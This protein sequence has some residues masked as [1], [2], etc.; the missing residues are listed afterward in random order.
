MTTA[1]TAII[2]EK[3]DVTLR[4]YALRCARAFGYCS[5]QRD[6]DMAA[7]PR[8]PEPSNEYG[9]QLLKAQAKCIELAR[10]SPEAA[11]ALWESHCASVNK[12]NAELEAHRLREVATYG[13]MRALVEAWVPPTKDHAAL[14]SFMLS[15]IRECTPDERG[16][17]MHA[18]ASPEELLSS[19]RRSAER[20]V[21]Y[22]TEKAANE[23][24]WHIKAAAWIRALDESLP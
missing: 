1:Y 3:P 19:L 14:K 9:E 7:P 8:A 2:E 12:W 5:H 17:V 6:E 21:E 23:A 18:Y 20:D 22:Y 11:R 4:E 24:I 16:A 13:R 10:V 15:Q